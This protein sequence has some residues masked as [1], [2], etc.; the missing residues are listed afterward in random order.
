MPDIPAL[1]RAR[2]SGLVLALAA[3]AAPRLAEAQTIPSP[4]RFIEER[5]AV[6]LQL[7]YLA[8]D[9]GQYGW[10][11]KSGPLAG[12]RWGIMVGGTF[13]IELGGWYSPTSRDVIDLVRAEDAQKIGE[14]DM[15][16][17]AGLADLRFNLVGDRTWNRLTPFLSVGGGLIFDLAGTQNADLLLEA[18]RRFKMGTSILAR[19]G[20]GSTLEVT[21]HLE[22]RGDVV[23]Q[24]YQVDTPGGWL[25]L[26]PELGPLAPDQWVNGWALTLGAGWR[27]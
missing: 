4:Y 10:G 2:L 24:L 26:E 19:A 8:T 6:N 18:D 20:F 13:V 12:L 7:G 1:S 22:L 23:F 27:F 3:L 5:Q 17:L 9:P 14:A 15:Q 25:Q 11:P 16:L 21:R